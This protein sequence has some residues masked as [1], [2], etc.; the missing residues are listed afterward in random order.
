LG[1]VYEARSVSS[2]RLRFIG[3]LLGLG[4]FKLISVPLLPF[5]RDRLD[6]E[7][8][9]QRLEASVAVPADPAAR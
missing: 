8:R 5:G 2:S 3:I 9:A 4:N 7:A 1:V 6:R